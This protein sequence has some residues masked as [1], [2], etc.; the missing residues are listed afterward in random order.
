MNMQLIVL[1]L[2]LIISVLDI[3]I[4]FKLSKK[5]KFIGYFIMLTGIYFVVVFT[6]YSVLNYE[7]IINGFINLSN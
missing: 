1:I 3:V 7:S 2:I 5:K 4:G 6:L